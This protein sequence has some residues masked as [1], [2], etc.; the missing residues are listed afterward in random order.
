MAGEPEN[1]SEGSGDSPTF[2]KK[3]L[4]GYVGF[5]NLPNQVHRKAVKLGFDFNVLVVGESGL[6]KSTLINS[7]FLADLYEDRE[8]PSASERISTTVDITST[9]VE[10]DEKGVKLRLT[11]VDT[12][13]FGDSV[14]NDETWEP[15]V[16][17]VEEQFETFLNEESRVNRTRVRDG[18]IHCCLY[19]IAP[20]GHG[21][22]PL[23]VECMKCLEKYVN[24]VPV[25]G[26]SDSLTP[27]ELMAFKR[28]VLSDI[29]EYSIQIY[30]PA[31]DSD[32]EDDMISENRA[33]VACVPFAVIGS[34][35]IV[36][37]HGKKVRARVYPWG[38]VEIENEEHCDFTRLRN[39]LI[40]THMQDLKDSTNEVHYE[41]YRINKLSEIAATEANAEG[42]PLTKYEAERREQERK[43]KFKEEEMKRVFE[44]KVAE[45]EMKL[46]EAESKLKQQHE[47][48][49]RQL[50]QQKLELERRERAFEEEKAKVGDKKKKSIFK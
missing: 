13:G 15:I 22:K 49:Q 28:R 6:G 34:N 36:E 5:G 29:E 21:L 18:R 11:I 10:I 3:N 19:F 44:Y 8:Y 30:S 1:D 50:Q 40:R 39:M 7:L 20:T 16:S 4:S 43:L 33:V 14:N 32:D 23:D 45:K 41:N 46:K 47:E 37:S 35:A 9:S 12:P 17:Y 42:N 38:V 24:I 31:V 2:E 25:I 27:E 48:M 26:K